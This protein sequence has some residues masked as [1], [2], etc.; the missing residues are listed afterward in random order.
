MAADGV[1]I[2]NGATGNTIGGTT[3]GA[4]NVISGNR[5]TGWRSQD[6]GSSGNV[7]EGNYIGT[8]VTGDA[9]LGNFV[10]NPAVR[11]GQYHRRHGR[12]RWQHHRRQRWNRLRLQ[13]ISDPDRGEPRPRVGRQ[14][15]RG[16]LHRPR[17]Q[18]PGPGRRDRRGHRLR[19][20]H[21]RRHH[22]QHDRRHH[23]RCPQRDLGKPSGIGMA[24]DNGN[25]V[26]GNYIGTDPTGTIAIGN[27]NG[28]G[29][30]DIDSIRCDAMTRSA[31]PPPAPEISFPATTFQRRCGIWVSTDD[32]LRRRRQLHRHRRDRDVALPNYDGI[33]FGRRRSTATTRSAGRPPRPG[34]GRQPHRGQWTRHLYLQDNPASL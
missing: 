2:D 31:A 25:L 15:D 17:R 29:D 8:D 7:V 28:Y 20:A 24:G 13:R 18:R 22:R 16:E 14:P 33:D 10:R 9:A 32:R 21:R 1:E 5:E 34:R 12:G 6:T 26:E 4:R 3:A 11:V 23:G 30:V 19:R 27:G